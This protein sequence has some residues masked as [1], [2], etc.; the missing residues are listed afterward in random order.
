MKTTC[1]LLRYQAQV[2]I[3]S[4]RYV[5]PFAALLIFLG[6]LYAYRPMQVVQGFSFSASVLCFV[7]VAIGL[8]YPDVEDTVSEQ[9][10]VLKMRSAARYETACVLFVGLVG[11]ALAVFCLLF[12]VLVD[13]LTG[14]TL[15]DEPLR[16][17]DAL[18]GLAVHAAMAFLGGAVGGLLHPRIVRDRKMAL[19]LAIFI[20]AVGLVKPGLHG[21]L[22]ATAWVTWLFPPVAE[23]STLFADKLAFDGL[24]VLRAAGGALLYGAAAS[25]ARVLLLVRRGY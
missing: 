24:T 11:V 17:S 2:Y 15:F 13:A 25:V 1:N 22:P 10:L 5:L 6:G 3:R 9:L 21:L 4:A 20:C 12:G 23:V 16:L 19:L 7:M 14:F 8:S 18:Y